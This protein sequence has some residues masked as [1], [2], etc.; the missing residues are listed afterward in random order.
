MD[1]DD[2]LIGPRE[3]ADQTGLP[4]SWIYSKAEAGVLPHYKIGKYIRFRPSEVRTWLEAQRRG[5]IDGP[6]VTGR[7]EA[8]ER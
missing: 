6:A 7:S 5:R 2:K 1:D 3:L 4:V 8:P